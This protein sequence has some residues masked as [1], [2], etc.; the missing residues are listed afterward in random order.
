MHH[1]PKVTLLRT[2]SRWVGLRVAKVISLCEEKSENSQPPT[3]KLIS[4]TFIAWRYS[5]SRTSCKS[6]WQITSFLVTVS[7]HDLPRVVWLLPTYYSATLSSFST[8]G[9]EIVWPHHISLQSSNR[10]GATNCFLFYDEHNHNL[11]QQKSIKN[12]WHDARHR[13]PFSGTMKMCYLCWNRH[14]ALEESFHCQHDLHLG[15]RVALP[16]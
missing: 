11:D 6:T 16:Y 8:Q 12:C 14:L 10:Q 4:L 3:C 1:L 9:Q 15:E 2:H 5:L 7:M 13:S